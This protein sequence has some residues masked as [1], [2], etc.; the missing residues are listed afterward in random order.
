VAKHA[1]RRLRI[2]VVGAGIGGL[3]AVVAL[4]AAG[5]QVTVVEREPALTGTGGHLG[6]QSNAVLALRRLGLADA[7]VAAG[8]P[9][10]RFELMSWSGR[11]L[12]WWSPGELGR[13]LAAPNVTVPRQVL[14]RALAEAAAE[15]PIRFGEP[16]VELAETP[17]EVVVRLL[18]GAELRA[19]VL[20]GADGIRSTVRRLLGLPGQPR[21]AGYRSWRA[22]T[23]A[24]PEELGPGVARHYLAPG[25]TFGCWPLPGGGTYW[26]ATRA[27]RLGDTPTTVPADDQSQAEHRELL[28]A[29]ADAPAAVRTLLAATEPGALLGLPVH[30]LAD[31]GAW[32]TGRVVLLGDAVH[33]MQPTTGQGAAQAMLDA[34]C[35]AEQLA[36]VTGPAPDPAELRH[37]FERYVQAR[38]PAVTAIAREAAG[39]GQ[40]HH[41]GNPLGRLVRDAVVRGT[42]HRV[43]QRRTRLRLTEAALLR[44]E[45]A[46]VAAVAR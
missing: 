5:H 35:L 38:W 18:G 4:H 25:R 17:S 10:E 27:Q 19:D 34:L 13:E 46:A 3:T 31:V 23:P 29:F 21:Y 36:A 39:L 11:R 45:P 12:A 7:V 14:L 37:A 15:V 44:V 1:D 26:V 43:W 20:V 32:S 24:R 9:V 28:R 22:R 33:A 30:S 8:V 42:P 2:V 41:V 6:V 40:M 16:L